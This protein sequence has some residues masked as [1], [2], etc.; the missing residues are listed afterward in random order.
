MP[1]RNQKTGN[2]GR[3]GFPASD[4]LKYIEVMMH[5]GIWELNLKTLTFRFSDNCW[6]IIG[7]RKKDQVKFEDLLNRCKKKEERE[8]LEKGILSLIRKGEEFTSEFRLTRKT[9]Q[10]E[11]NRTIL[12]HC[13][14]KSGGN[15]PLITGLFTDITS[16]KKLEKELFKAKN[17]AEAADRFK[18]VFLTNLS[19]EIRTP[20]NAI[21]GFAEL[22]NQQD[23]DA[24]LI[25]KFT[26]I[27]KNKGKYLMALIDDV[28][29]LSRFE[30]GSIGMNK[31]SF[32]LY[33]FFK[34]LF[35]EYIEGEALK[36]KTQ[37][38]LRL[39]VDE[40]DRDLQV[41]TD[42]GRL[43]QVMSN[44]IGNAI[45]FT[46]R[47]EVVFGYRVSSKK[48]KLFVEDTGIGL[49]PEDEQRIFNRFEEIEDTT[50]RKLGGSGLSLT[51]SRHIVEQL[52]GRIKVKSELGKGSI[53]QVNL[54]IDKPYNKTTHMDQDEVKFSGEIWKGRVILV[55][56]DEELNYRFLEVVLEKTG[57]RVLHARNGQEAVDLFRSIPHIDLVLMDIKMPIKSG[58]DATVEI[59]NLKNSVPVVAQTAFAVSEEI[60]KCKE[61]GCDD[62][63]TKPID[64]NLLIQK[65]N[66]FF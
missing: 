37:I 41:Y 45:K 18:S 1:L 11:E 36:S 48:L 60:A 21:M 25:K 43:H 22:L 59:K 56:E 4:D 3:Q 19:H 34:E 35:N 55:A 20:M 9:D 63:I 58:Y 46:E 50:V 16:R 28:I 62:Y 31:T 30:T 38:R 32:S 64:I 61:I 8:G 5:S 26:G 13:M 54:P 17:K 53:F 44:L 52:G 7:I 51:I 40:A 15:Y 49:R 29:E 65:I 6:P 10:L 57:A 14:V 12:L 66:K 2:K 23:T 33:P 39:E 47:G 42:S 24:E 27:I